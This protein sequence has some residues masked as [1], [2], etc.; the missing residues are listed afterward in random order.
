MV[1]APEDEEY[2]LGW[3]PFFVD[4]FGLRA[5]LVFKNPGRSGVGE[6]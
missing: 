6:R 5:R 2:R 4:I 3:R 1:L